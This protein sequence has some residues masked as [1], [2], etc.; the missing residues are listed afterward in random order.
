[1]TRRGG[2]TIRGAHSSTRQVLT[3]ELGPTR[4]SQSSGLRHAPHERP[5]GGGS[6]PAPAPCPLRAQSGS[7]DRPASRL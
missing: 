1:M 4:G 2:Q 6:V 3:H 7:P 5:P